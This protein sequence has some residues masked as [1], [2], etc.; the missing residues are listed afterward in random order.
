MT[1]KSWALSLLFL[2][3]CSA[4]FAFAQTTYT[5]TTLNCSLTSCTN[6]QFSPTAKLSYSNNLQHY[7]GTFTGAVIWNGT[8]YTDFTGSMKWLGYGNHYPFATWLIQGTFDGGLYTVSETFRCFRSCGSNVA[9]TVVGPLSKK[10]NGCDAV[11]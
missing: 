1:R 5:Q 8:A 4:S 6:A 11:R 2:L 3:L 10:R 9:G 7:G